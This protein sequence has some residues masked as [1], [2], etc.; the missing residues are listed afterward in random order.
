MALRWKTEKP[1]EF[2]D[3]KGKQ[4]H[5]DTV[6]DIARFIA[7]ALQDEIKKKT[8]SGVKWVPYGA[9]N[10][11]P[12]RTTN[13]I[14]SIKKEVKGRWTGKKYMWVVSTD[15]K[16]APYVEYGTSPHVI[17]PKKPGGS[18]VYYTGGDQDGAKMVEHPGTKPVYMF[19]RG[20]A[21]T[22][23]KVGTIALPHLYRWS[24]SR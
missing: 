17:R 22:R 24:V 12:V 13:L 14:D 19:T 11:A 2:F 21:Q 5:D 23:P 6:P 4:L 1:H 7:E 10:A 9:P 20:V 18:L 8:P 15:K 3:R 16:Y